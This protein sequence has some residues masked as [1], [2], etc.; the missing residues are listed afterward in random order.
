MK[1]RLLFQ[2]VLSALSFSGPVLADGAEDLRS[3]LDETVITTASTSA[4]TGSSAP[5]TSTTLTAEDLRTYGIRS[6]D[7]AINFLSL[8]VITANPLSAVDIG[9]RGVLLPND[10]GKHFL[11]LVNGHAINDP[12][13]GAARF[14]HGAGIPLESIDHIE[15]IVGPGSVLYGSNAMLGVVNIIT[16]HAKDYGGT[17]VV[18]EYEP[19][20]SLRV[21]AGG[22]YSFSLFGTP[23][24]LTSEV[25]YYY[26]FGPN[27]DF[28]LQPYLEEISIGGPIRYGRDG[29]ATEGRWGGTVDEAYFTQVPSAQLQLKSGDFEANVMAALYRRGMPFTRAGIRVDFDDPESYEMD[30][31]LRVDLEHQATLSRDV[32][33]TTRVYADSFDYQRRINRWATNACYTTDI[34]TCQ[35]YTLGIARWAGVE[36]RLAVNWF[37]DSRL[38]T[39]AGI[40]ARGRWASGKEDT[41]DFDTGRP[42]APS[43]GLISEN[44][45]LVS[46]YLQ[47]TWTPAEWL[48]FNAG[49][50]LDADERYDEIVSPRVAVA[51]R[52]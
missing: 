26:R 21:G 23:S 33:L 11:L 15:V 27:L 5:A 51:V 3:L 22:G 47:Q 7:D 34:E 43:A 31:S 38:T 2:S 36:L 40:D 19:G 49:A 14:D 1:A 18:T 10:A 42:I 52:P 35:L 4:Q 13:I 46:P 39:M 37:G 24:S 20:R 17:H 12:L 41:L 9:A 32:S 30:R 29:G 8:G 16:K 44:A 48:D 6:V 45:W 28:D 25:G 50:R